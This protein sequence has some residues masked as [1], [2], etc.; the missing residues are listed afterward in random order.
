[1]NLR[2]TCALGGALLAGAAVPALALA[3]GSATIAG[4]PVVTDAVAET[5]NTADIGSAAANDLGCRSWWMVHAIRG[6]HLTIDF[7]GAPNTMEELYPAGT[8]D[9]NVED[10]NPLAD[11]RGSEQADADSTGVG[12]ARYIAPRDGSLPLA[13]SAP[14]CGGAA[15]VVGPYSFE[16]YDLHALILSASQVT[17][18]QTH[19]TTISLSARNGDGQAVTTPLTARLERPQGNRWLVHQNA[20]SVPATFTVTW[21]PGRRNRIQRVDLVVSGAGYWTTTKRMRFRAR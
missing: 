13:V 1:M 12:Q 15:T 2:R 5:G 18:P 6:D 10:T 14:S 11:S 9:F 16:V 19:T 17:D 7:N 4:A 21:T 3:D 8:D 20:T